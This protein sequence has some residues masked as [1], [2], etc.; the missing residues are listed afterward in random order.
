MFGQIVASLIA[1][2]PRPEGPPCGAPYSYGK[3]KDPSMIFLMV[4]MASSIAR[5]RVRAQD[6]G[7]ISANSLTETGILGLWGKDTRF[8]WRE[9]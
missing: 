5:G 7:H 1:E 8:S 3:V 2:L 6:G 4:I 9:F